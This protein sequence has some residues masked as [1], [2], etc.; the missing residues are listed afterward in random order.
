[1]KKRRLTHSFA[2]KKNLLRSFRFF[3]CAVFLCAGVPFLYAQA[4]QKTKAPPV[5]EI[6]E[7][8]SCRKELIETWFMQDPEIVRT[9]EPQLMQ[10]RV[11]DY[12]LV[13]QEEENG[14]M[15][16]IVAPLVRQKVL[17]AVNNLEMPSE[18]PAAPS[19]GEP[20][21]VS[22]KSAEKNAAAAADLQA[23]VQSV[24]VIP[25]NASIAS[26]P[27]AEEKNVPAALPPEN[28]NT[29]KEIWIETWP[30]TA[31]GSWVLYRDALTGKPLRIR[32]YIVPDG[33]VY[34][35]F[36][37]GKEKCLADFVVFGAVAAGGVPVPVGF[38]RFY[39]ATLEDLSRLTRYTLPWNYTKVFSYSYDGVKQMI[40]L[41]RFL[42]PSLHKSG[43][44][45]GEG[46]SLNF[47]KWIVDG[48]VKPLTGGTV[49]LEEEQTDAKSL[50]N[51]RTLAAAALSARTDI[52]YDRNTSGADV[53]TDAFAYY[54]DADGV[55][56][57]TGYVFNSG[58][59]VEL[60]KPLFYVLAVTEADRFF[61]GAVRQGTVQTAGGT[62]ER[63]VFTGTAVFFPWF[64]SQGRF[65]LS[66]FEKG[67][68]YTI[69]EFAKKYRGGFV[70]LVRVKASR[71]FFPERFEGISTRY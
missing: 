39:T 70:S 15:R 22:E 6:P 30:E 49:R 56:K 69:D 48:L 23:G 3:T 18:N 28:E 37:P 57:N 45:S 13:R 65:R 50:E 67:E 47:V 44:I 46:A 35:D 8:A 29:A 21:A 27:A 19:V 4:A 55:P 38:D 9:A 62:A 14:Q 5:R 63:Q 1:M 68:E 58:Y 42:L 36:F 16:I 24:T 52:V 17:M 54:I 61:L 20:A 11:G 10:N 66:V 59:P 2:R 64:D 43:K 51:I 53:K 71:D 40:G 31:P 12:F 41:V 32:Y 34:A 33:E 25:S 60:L 7:S 26:A